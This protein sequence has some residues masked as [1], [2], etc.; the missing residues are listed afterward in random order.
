MPLIFSVEHDM[1]DTAD[2][3]FSKATDSFRAVTAI[4]GRCWLRVSLKG[5]IIV[6]ADI[7]I[8]AVIAD[9]KVRKNDGLF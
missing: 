4:S 6:N 2:A 5:D 1:S 8:C 9:A 7:R 3:T